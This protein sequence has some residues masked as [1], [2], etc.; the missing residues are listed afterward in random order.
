MTREGSLQQVDP[1]SALAARPLTVAAAV[2]TPLIGLALAL[3]S[4]HPVENPALMAAA[5]A[6][7]VGASVLLVWATDARRA[8]FAG[9]SHTVVVALGCL[10]SLLAA[11]SSWGTNV[12]ARDDWGS[13]CLGVLLAACAPYRPARS[14]LAAAAAAMVFTASLTIWQSPYFT[15]DAPAMVFVFIAVI[16]VASLSLAGAAY[17]DSAV[18]TRERWHAA[19]AEATRALVDG[20]RDAVS[21]LSPLSGPVADER[22]AV[23]SHGVVPLFARVLR[24]GN[25]TAHDVAQAREIS[26]EVRGIMVAEAN[27]SWLGEA[28]LEASRGGVSA[29]DSVADGSAGEV[30]AG[31]VVNSEVVDS[32]VVADAANYSSSMSLVQ[33]TAVRAFLDALFALP[34]YPGFSATVI[35]NGIFHDVHIAVGVRASPRSQRRALAPY[36]TVMRT[37]FPRVHLGVDS[38]ELTLRFSYEH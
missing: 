1:L 20:A 28:V 13:L 26:E 33:R 10:A 25:I 17:A 5:F 2:A 12:T 37:V 7:L 35:P 34:A 16:P 8:P 22:L 29:G 4:R 31:R 24:Q 38:R 36:I 19:A 11:L 14:L 9:G 32:A 18:R 23:L 15:A 6:S 30:A 3:H 21:P 27:R